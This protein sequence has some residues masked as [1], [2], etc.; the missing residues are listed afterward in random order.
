MMLPGTLV[1]F[2]T[3][4]DL[5]LYAMI[6]PS[7]TGDPFN[8]VKCHR[9]IVIGPAHSFD[10]TEYALLLTPCGTVGW[11]RSGHLMTELDQIC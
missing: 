4:R 6:D 9:F 11:M 8:F 2:S 5:C 7:I 3:N 1:S 10:G